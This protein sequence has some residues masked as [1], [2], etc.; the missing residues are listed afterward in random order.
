MTDK[1]QDSLPA[2]PK[3]RVLVIEDET[4]VAIFVEQLLADLGCEVVGPLADMPTAV[5]AAETASI[6]AAILNLVI[7]GVHAY[8]VAEILISR[9]IPFGFASGVPHDGVAEAWRHHPFLS[10]PYLADE[11]GRLLAQLI[12]QWRG[13][14][15]RSPDPSQPETPMASAIQGE[16]MPVRAPMQPE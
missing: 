15:G 3:P 14:V 10:K 1:T 9:N 7:G 13:P 11:L 6:D 8:P 16:P 12:P 5:H 4:L 2:A